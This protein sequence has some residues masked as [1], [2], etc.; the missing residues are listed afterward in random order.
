M[1]LP[2]CAKRLLPLLAVGVLVFGDDG[3]AAVIVRVAPDG[4]GD[5]LTIQAAVDDVET[6]STIF[7]AP[8]IYDETVDLLDKQLTIE[9]ENGPDV[10]IIEPTD[11]TGF[12]LQDGQGLATVLAGFTIRNGT[13]YDVAGDRRGGA[14]YLLN[15]TPT[16]RD[17]RFIDN[18]ANYAAA[19]Y[20]ESGVIVVED[21]EFI[22]N[23][24]ERYGGAIAGASSGVKLFRSHF[25]NN[26]AGTGDGV[27]HLALGS[28][29]QDCSF[30]GNSSRAGAAINAGG[31]GADFTVVRSVFIDNRATGRHGGAIRVHEAD[32]IANECLFVRNSAALDG[33]AIHVIDGGS[34]RVQN[35]TLVGNWADRFGDAASSYSSIELEKC[36]VVGSPSSPAIYCAGQVNVECS[37]FWDNPF[38]VTDGCLSP[39]GA[40]GNFVDDPLFCA[41]ESD[42]YSL[43]DSSPCLPGNHPDDETCGRIGAFDVGCTA[44]DVTGPEVAQTALLRLGSIAPNPA[45]DAFTLSF[46]IATP[47]FVDF[48]AFA[49]DGRRFDLGRAWYESGQHVSEFQDPR[50]P[51]GV[52]AVRISSPAGSS[53]KKLVIR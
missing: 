34:A 44:A 53:S 29:I 52:Y 25:E 7:V 3:F 26:R 49:I 40:D 45:S 38:G 6:G 16:I 24:A 21:C 31:F 28:V 17:C 46:E 14:I 30:I 8:G 12:V 43:L 36:I 47:G 50:L 2:S 41:A 1:W 13:G 23:E 9:S 20:L 10:T 39:V 51:N 5:Y 35:S 48:T 11:G 33:G 37:T 27:L 18:W 4:T 19:I 22:G 15:T 42:D 32:L